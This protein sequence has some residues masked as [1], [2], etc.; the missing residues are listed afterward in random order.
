MHFFPSTFMTTLKHSGPTAVSSWAAQKRINVFEKKLLFVPV[1]ADLHW[2]LCVIVNPGLI[3][4]NHDGDMA[5]S[6]EHSL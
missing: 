4:N 5:S 6:E 3:A 2:S 1:H